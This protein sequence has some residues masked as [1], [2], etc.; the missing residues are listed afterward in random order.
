MTRP[1][2]A[3]GGAIPETLWTANDVAAYLK[4][5]RSWVYHR[6]ESGELPCLRVGAL[7]RFEP[8][9]I[10]AYARGDRP[11]TALVALRSR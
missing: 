3:G 9:R 4:V 7:V 10:K 6:C 8:E 5:S 1:G 2:D 11:L